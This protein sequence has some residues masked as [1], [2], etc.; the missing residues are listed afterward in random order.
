MEDTDRR[1]EVAQLA[2][3]I[4][5]LCETSEAPLV[6]LLRKCHRL[7][8]AA[9]R[10]DIVLWT[11]LEQQGVYR[12]P[13]EMQLQAPMLMQNYENTA[14]YAAMLRFI[15]TRQVRTTNGGVATMI[16]AVSE[17]EGF[18]DI[19]TDANGTIQAFTNEQ[20]AFALRNPVVLDS[21]RNEVHRAACEILA[22]YKFG[23]VVQGIF[24]QARRLVDTRL[25]SLAP[26]AASELEAAY[27]QLGSAAG[28]EDLAAAAN[29]C[30]RVL[31]DLADAIRPVGQGNNYGRDC[32][33]DKYVNRL[34]AYACKQ[35]ESETTTAALVA[36][37]D[38]LAARI[39]TVNKLAHKGTHGDFT[40]AEA[41]MC[42]IHT[43]LVVADLLQLARVDDPAE[44]QVQ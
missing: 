22:A 15:R 7:G 38:H 1:E 43:Y 29:A 9:G 6:D 3:E 36:D 37:I 31:Q 17:I 34:C 16:L 5:R 35:I 19:V 4:A 39:D 11:L 10:D 20:F 27:A 25:V 8:T 18:Q 28:A 26:E 33:P 41:R 42:L 13:S 24:E 14:K 12:E 40:L 2:E 30:R 23:D 44:D 32:G 21:I